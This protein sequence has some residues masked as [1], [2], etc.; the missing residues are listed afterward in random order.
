MAVDGEHVYVVHTVLERY[1]Y[2]DLE[3]TKSDDGGTTWALPKK[4]GK[5]V[6]NCVA[7]D[8]TGRIHVAW[9]N[10]VEH[11]VQ[12][13]SS[14]DGGETWSAQM[15]VGETGPS[16]DLFADSVSLII[17]CA[18]DK[19]GTHVHLVWTGDTGSGS[20]DVW[21]AHSGDG[22]STWDAPVRVNDDPGS[23]H[24][25]RA[26]IAVD[27]KGAVHTAWSDWRTGGSR[28]WASW[29]IDHGATWSKNEQ[30]SQGTASESGPDYNGLAVSPAGEVGFAWADDRHQQTGVDVW[31]SRRKF[32]AP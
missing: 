8:G 7:T 11:E 12:Y 19:S 5:G 21:T 10:D 2:G 27:Q 32:V 6:G 18:T 31:F 1:L 17:G 29:S 28:P 25:V 24:Q 3:F 14:S 13:R 15:R 20:W 16:A 4:L 9:G 23:A 22:G 26:W 30:I